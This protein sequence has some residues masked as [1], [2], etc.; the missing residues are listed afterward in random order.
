MGLATTM[1]PLPFVGGR[2]TGQMG[3]VTFPPACESTTGALG[4]AT[5]TVTETVRIRTRTERRDFSR[6]LKK[7]EFILIVLPWC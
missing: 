5:A 3:L 1:L 2:G 6:K 4:L 7:E